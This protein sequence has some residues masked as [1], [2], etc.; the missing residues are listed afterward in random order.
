ML[1]SVKGR[2]KRWNVYAS[3]CYFCVFDLLE[4]ACYFAVTDASNTF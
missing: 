3:L 4:S 1:P 2:K